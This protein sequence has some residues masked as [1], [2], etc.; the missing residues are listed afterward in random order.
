MRQSGK[1]ALEKLKDFFFGGD[2]EGVY[3]VKQLYTFQFLFCWKVMRAEGVLK[4]P[5][6]VKVDLA[7][8]T[9]CIK[10]NLKLIFVCKTSFDIILKL[11]SYLENIHTEIQGLEY[12]T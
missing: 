10:L 3:I 9:R 11:C 7:L 6:K 4:V 8:Y 12:K 2:A 5:R 1:K